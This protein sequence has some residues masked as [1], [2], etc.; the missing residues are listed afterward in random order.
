MI[1]LVH[2]RYNYFWRIL[3]FVVGSWH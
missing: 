3:C 1:M 2:R